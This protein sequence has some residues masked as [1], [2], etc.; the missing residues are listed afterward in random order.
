MQHQS[1]TIP[2]L[3]RMKTGALDRVGIY[4]R[5]A[6]RKKVVM[7]QSAG[8]PEPIVQRAVESLERERIELVKL[9]EPEKASLEAATEVFA[10]LSGSFDAI[11]G[12]GGGKALDMA[13]FLAVL[14]NRPYYAIPTSLSNDGFCSPQASLTVGGRRKSIGARIPAGIIVD[15]EVCLAAPRPLWWSG[16]GDLVSK[17][18]AVHDWRLA[19]HAD[20]TPFNDFAALLSD[21]TVHQFISSP[22]RDT[23][24]IRVLATALMLNGVAMEIC[25]NSRPASGGEHLVSHALDSFSKRP[26]LH[27]LQVGVATYIV[28]HLQGQGTDSIAD[29]LAKTNFWAAFQ[30]DPLDRAEWIEAFRRAPGIKQ[31]FHTILSQPGYMDEV[32]RLLREDPRLAAVFGG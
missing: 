16:V 22:A 3:V 6:E 12:L 13:K 8:L 17:I 1:P 29:V 19:F 23:A 11:I 26:R 20:G 5:R 4:M 10:G 2:A 18:T 14:A 31:D 15:L 9:A 30:D 21:A 24:G 25:G 27:G 28:S 7:L 32:E